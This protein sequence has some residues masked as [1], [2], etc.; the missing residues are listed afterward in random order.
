MAKIIYSPF[1]QSDINLLENN[2]CRATR[3]VPNINKLSYHERWE[4]LD[5][6]NLSNRRLGGSLIQT[7]KILHGYYDENCISSLFTFKDTV[8]TGKCKTDI[9]KNFFTLRVAN[10]WNSLFSLIKFNMITA[11]QC[12]FWCD[13]ICLLLFL[14][15]HIYL[16]SI[17]LHCRFLSVFFLC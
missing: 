10:L 14:L 2:Q 11:T 12:F 1:L 6:P 9:R 3:Y 7:V 4:A 15:L 13:L 5:L 8:T 17:N 16:L